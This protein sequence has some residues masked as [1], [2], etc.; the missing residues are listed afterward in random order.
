MRTACFVIPVAVL[1]SACTSPGGGGGDAGVRADL[2]ADPGDEALP[3]VPEF[4]EPLTS[5]EVSRAGWTVRW[6]FGARELSFRR[7]EDV[8]LRFPG[9]GLLI[10]RVDALDDAQSYDPWWMYPASNAGDMYAPPAGLAWL[11]PTSGVAI[12]RDEAALG[13]HLVYPEGLTATLLVE[14]EADGRFRVTWK[15]EG[16]AG[17]ALAYFRLR[18]RADAA[19]GF[20]G[21]GGV[22]D[23]PNHR[24]R[25]RP[26]QVEVDF[27]A[28]SAN[29]EAHVRVPLLIGTR[30]WGLFVQSLRGMA[31]DVARQADD[32]VE[33]TVGTGPATR[34][35]LGFHLFGADRP[36][37][38]TARY[39]EVTGK[40]R[41]PARWALGPWVW[42]DEG[43]DQAKVV[44]DM[45]A[46]RDHDLA[47]TGYW[48]DRPYASAVNSFPF[49]PADYDDP[50]AMIARGHALGLRMALWHTPYADPSDPDSKPLYDSAKE[51]GYFP[52][53]M[54]T[55]F[56]KWGPPLD[57]TNPA[58]VA[59][60]QS[61]LERYTDMGIEGWKLDYA[62]EVQLGV[63]GQRTPWLFHD[64]SD[65]RTMHHRYQELY[66][67]TYAETLP[68]DGGFLLCRTGL[69]GDQ[70]NGV[71]VWP[72]DLDASF[73]RHGDEVIRD[74]VP[75]KAVGGLPA[76]MVVGLSL[77][78]SGFP[79][80]GADT[81][82]YIDLA[83]PPD[84]E[85]FT[86]WFEQ[87]ALSS[88]MQVGNG[89][90]TV[91]WELGGPDGYDEEMLGWYRAYARLHLR[92]FPLEWTLA[93]RLLS[94]GRPI[95]RPFGLQAPEAGSHPWD[96]Y[97]FGDDLLVAPVTERGSR[98]RTVVFPAGDWIDWWNGEVV[99]GP[100]TLERDAPLHVLP[101][102]LR[103]GGIVPMLRPTIDAIAPTTEPARVDSYAT[104]PGVLHVRVAPGLASSFRV[105]DGTEVG[106]EATATGWTLSYPSGQEF[107][108]GAEFELSP[109][110]ARPVA[111][112]MDG[113]PL[114]ELAGV[115]ALPI[116]LDPPAA[117]PSPGWSWDPARG[118]VL[119]VRVPAGTHSI[120]ATR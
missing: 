70:A 13:L 60:W 69:F 25:T 94:D 82:G 48:I 6:D 56:A 78:P 79:F 116:G 32:L 1:L 43:V 44:A 2:A 91:P 108:E 27:D 22:H 31:F 73:H 53:V 98:K 92:L 50:A 117:L 57:Y 115:P 68:A 104:S 62:E 72:G 34:D 42:R 67:R 33:V 7:G 95:Q 96:Q 109:V 5:V 85:L 103:A 55:A 75:K 14:A 39:Y 36:L 90:S 93:T 45:E 65:E 29:N 113:A 89:E 51:K 58:A 100:A 17:P 120:L 102:F 16:D 49:E 66:H 4:H 37:D 18:P 119:R 86:R 63:L 59:W 74:G 76:S 84:K 81:G 110:A 35:G 46:I 71:I 12:R 24:G 3:D 15:P 26:M 111:V 21:L 99:T 77:G 19:E 80:Y 28:E 40:P 54:A 64:G 97:F 88:V 87:T 105:H 41:L 101:L 118:G 10:G 83:G 11:A 38:V 20:Y 52:P 8:R 9:D 107:V 61:L 23:H 47:T 30:G 112:A 114:A 106:Q